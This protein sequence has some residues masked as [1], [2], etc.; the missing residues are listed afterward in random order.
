MKFP[1]ETQAFNQKRYA[2]LVRVSAL[3]HG[4]KLIAYYIVANVELLL[5]LK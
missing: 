5:K 3:S 2:I 4:I 1:N